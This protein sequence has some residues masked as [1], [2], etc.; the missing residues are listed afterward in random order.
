MFNASYMREDFGRAAKHYD[1]HALLQRDV[2]EEV[3]RLVER[4]IP[5]DGLLLDVGAGTGFLARALPQFRHMIQLDIAWGMC[6]ESRHY[7]RR[8]VNADM[9]HLPFKAESCDGIISS[10]ALQWANNPQEIITELISPL[11]NK[12]YYIF[13]V[14]TRNTL[15]E[16][17]DILTQVGLSEHISHF[18]DSEQWASCLAEAGFDV[19]DIYSRRYEQH[20]DSPMELLRHFKLI[21]AGNKRDSRRNRLT[22]GQLRSITDIYAQRY[23]QGGRVASDWEVLYV[24]GQ[25]KAV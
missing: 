1:E 12:K 8:V 23:G 21:G 19:V 15:N 3:A 17:S 9:R 11:K 13:S 4:Y 7:S 24:V 10:L 25:K 5:H 2:A 20:Y 18:Y 14:F 16:L 6:E 22:R